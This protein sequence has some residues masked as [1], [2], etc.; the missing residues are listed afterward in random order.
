MSAAFGCGPAKYTVTFL[1]FASG[2]KQ[3][4][5][6]MNYLAAICA[7]LGDKDRAFEFLEKAF[8]QHTNLAPSLKSIP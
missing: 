2:S 7:R 3:R 4:Y 1:S 8:D 5:I 6:Q